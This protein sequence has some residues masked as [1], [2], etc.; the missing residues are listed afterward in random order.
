M[1]SDEQAMKK[2]CR[3]AARS[4]KIPMQQN[5]IHKKKKREKQPQNMN[6][7]TM[8]RKSAEHLRT[9]YGYGI[10]I[11]SSLKISNKNILKNILEI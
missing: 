2:S 11:F 4:D 10:H 5:T 7:I 3:L 9:I 6:W 1:K 8:T